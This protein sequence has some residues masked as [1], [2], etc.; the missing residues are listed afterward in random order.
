M[1]Q[2]VG[3]ERA[4]S[5]LTL[6]M[7]KGTIPH[8][9]LFTGQPHVGKMTLAI[10]LARAVNCAGNAAP[11]GEC[12]NCRRISRG[13]HSDVQII[14][15]TEDKN[16]TKLQKDISIEQIRDIQRQV[17]LPPFEG[18]YRV[19]IINDADRFSIEAAN[20]LL[21]TLEEPA[22]RVVFILLATDDR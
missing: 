5:L 6:G 11:C 14:S 3:H 21:K 7:G 17:N 15:L 20:C 18:K 22:G 16:H 9:Y 19:F 4:V 8:A 1:W 10:D 12:E 13:K 2:V